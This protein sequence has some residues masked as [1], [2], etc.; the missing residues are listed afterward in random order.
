LNQRYIQFPTKFRTQGKIQRSSCLKKIK[1]TVVIL[2]KRRI[3]LKL[4]TVIG[5]FG[6]LNINQTFVII[7]IIIIIITIT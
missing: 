7:I 6:R 3:A 2:T 5:S 1:Q 4:L